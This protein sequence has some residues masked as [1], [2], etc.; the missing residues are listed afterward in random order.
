[1]MKP[2]LLIF[3]KTPILGK[4]KTR[5]AQAI[6]AQRALAIHQI[7]VKKTV[8]VIAPLSVDKALFFSSSLPP[9]EEQNPNIQ[10]YKQQKGDN[11]GAR[12]EQA[13]AWGFKKGYK[14]IVI[15]GTDLWEL[16]TKTLET[17]FFT[18]E[19][20]KTVIGPATDGGYYLL[21]LTQPNTALFK[22]KQWGWGSVLEDT[23]KDLH[24]ERP[25]LLPPKTDIDYLDDLLHFPDLEKLFHQLPK[26]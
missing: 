4:V 12:M 9:K 26:E 23:L 8:T 6:G 21:G 16:D 5:L 19:K 11:L 14:K 22:N 1:M 15:I 25:F 3:T 17:A 10:F 13:F 24:P 2:L 18:L 20:N 7:L